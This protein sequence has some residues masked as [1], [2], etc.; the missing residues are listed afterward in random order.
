MVRL[1][2]S[3]FVA[4]N[5]W[6][7]AVI[8]QDQEAVWVQIEAQ[9]S[10]SKAQDRVR[11]YSAAL[12][13]VNGFSLGGGWYAIAL[14][15]Y[16]PNDAREVLRVYRSEGQIP[17]DSYIAYSAS[18]RQQ[19][20][21]VG[22]NLLTLTPAQ[23]A[24]AAAIIA[25]ATE[26]TPTPDT[27]QSEAT[28]APEP[29]TI[30]PDETLSEALASE[31]ELT[32]QE[33]EKLQIAL[34]WAGHYDSSIDGAFGRGTR[35]SMAAWQSAN[36][37]QTTGVMTT[38]QRTELLSQYNAIL[39][40]LDVSVIEDST[41]G[42][43][44][45]MPTK[46]VRFSKYSPPFAHYDSIGD[47]NGRVLLISQQGDQNTLYGL[48]DIMQTLEIV[49]ESGPRERRNNSF[50]LV[51]EGAAF[52]SHT[53]AW[54]EDGAIK[55]FTL[56][57]PAGDEE[58]RRRLLSEMLSSFTRLD[59]AMDASAGTDDQS[60]DLVAGLEI[61]RPKLSRS[62]FFLD[63]KG[64]IVTTT[65]A[66]T[67][68]SHITIE[69]AFEAEILVND[70]TAGIAIIKSVEALSPAQVA[71][72]ATSE[73]RLQTEVAVSG[74]SYE[75]VLGAP[76]LTFGTL[77]DVKGLDGEPELKRLALNA[78]PGDAGGPVFDEAGSILGMLLPSPEGGRQ[79]PDL[80]SFAVDAATIQKVAQTAGL[81][82]DSTARPGRI[83]PE[84]LTAEAQALTV[85][86]SCW[87]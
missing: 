55:G 86:V 32:R 48:Y 57:W 69:N 77:S 24:P 10:L 46:V 52:I 1:L 73:P 16:T 50:T 87:E 72:L 51:G 78:L 36:N 76:T 62:G 42:I 70:V 31:A 47:I 79:L 11:D 64:H 74:F 23:E 22:A 71:I 38:S 2:V 41:A 15:P 27:E 59:G 82:A 60:V 85:L 63:Q 13:D 56:I 49:P 66:V 83:A 28:S 19:F 9:P 4:V 35:N 12:P 20:W 80:V 58:R 75:G 54:L 37:H 14:G 8:A 21:P 84:D 53:E 81:S 25:E 43:A 61:R 6:V 26:P 68:C 65:E 7:S 33:R 40:E 30:A 39:S 18:F 44:I 67:A 45:K 34:Q 3:V 5:F 29:V 17:R